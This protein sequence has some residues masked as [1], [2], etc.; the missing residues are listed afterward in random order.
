MLIV[1][2]DFYLEVKI[3]TNI[4][5]K[6][7]SRDSNDCQPTSDDRD[8]RAAAELIQQTIQQAP[9]LTYFVLALLYLGQQ[10]DNVPIKADSACSLPKHIIVKG[11]QYR[12]V[13][14]FS[15]TKS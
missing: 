3:K 10:Q 7:Q 9:E 1:C 5:D 13:M 12:G 14:P 2:F 15:G 11:L 8:T 6:L 4:V